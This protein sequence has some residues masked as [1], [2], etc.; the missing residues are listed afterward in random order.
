M[1]KQ[2]GLMPTCWGPFLWGFI[3]SIAYVYNPLTDKEKYYDFF[4]NMGFI[5]PC[6]ECRIHYVQNLNKQ[7]LMIALQSNENLFK[8]TYDLHNKVNL[9]TGVPESKWPSYES[10]KQRYS[11]Y[12]A[13]CSDIPGVCGSNS[14]VK[15]GIKMVEQFGPINEEQ[16]PYIAST[17][18]LGILLLIAIIYIIYLSTKSCPKRI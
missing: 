10:V 12:E 13:T 14:S 7:E 9:Q 18:T 8:W 6:D 15:R 16:I 4:S 2:S 3:H 1:D 5:L 11:S 17:T